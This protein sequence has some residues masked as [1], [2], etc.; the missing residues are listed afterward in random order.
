[1]EFDYTASI[2]LNDVPVLSAEQLAASVITAVQAGRR[3]LALFGLPETDGSG[4]G[5]FCLLADDATRTLSAMRTTPLDAF[6]SMTPQCPQVHLFERELFE[7]WRIRP[8][9]HPWLKPVRYCPPETG[10]T[11]RPGPAETQYYRVR[12]SQVHEVAVGPVHAGIIE[13]GHFRFQCYGENVMHLEI[14]LGFQHRGIEKLIRNAPTHRLLPLLECVAGDSSIAHATA[15]CTLIE[16]LAGTPVSIRGQLIRRVALELERLANHTGDL[17]AIG[18]DTGFLPTSAWNGRIRGDFLNMTALICGNRFG[19]GL[20]RPGGVLQDVDEELCQTVIKKLRAAYRDVRGAV[21]VM[22]AS[23]SVLARLTGTGRV[24][25]QAALD[26][27]LVGM[28]ARAC[29]LPRDARFTFPVDEL[30]LG[31]MLPRTETSGDVLARARVRSAELNDAAT[32]AIAALTHIPFTHPETALTDLPIPVL[33][34]NR[35]AVGIAEGWRGEICHVGITDARGAFRVYKIVDPSFHNWMGLA[36]ALRDEQISDF[37]LCNKSFNL[38]Y[39]GH[40]L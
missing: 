15:G 9:G 5:L 31:D 6:D 27:G 35:C 12:G 32:S 14:Q 26:L 33:P 37:P 25:T 36:M 20:L 21:D 13:P 28:A 4:V 18:G 16:R 30:P 11:E 17:G 1:M 19:R 34:A 2:E 22:F 23:Q 8:E 39:C 40:D 10:E 29:G 24:S 38:S 3:V 7:Q